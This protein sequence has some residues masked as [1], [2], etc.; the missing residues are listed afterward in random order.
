LRSRGDPRALK[1]A[2]VCRIEDEGKRPAVGILAEAS[3][4]YNQALSLTP[5]EATTEDAA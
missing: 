1:A 5:L 3:E 4:A 2:V